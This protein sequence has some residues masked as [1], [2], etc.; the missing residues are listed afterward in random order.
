MSHR[1]ELRVCSVCQVE[2]VSFYFSKAQWRKEKRIC[3]HCQNKN[4]C[5]SI[6]LQEVQK[7]TQN[8]NCNILTQHSRSGNVYSPSPL[9]SESTKFPFLP[10]D[11]VISDFNF[12]VS[13]HP[14]A[15]LT[16]TQLTIQISP[17]PKSHEEYKL[18]INFLYNQLIQVF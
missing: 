18:V 4:R 13:A 1:S 5:E 2:K 9:P 14:S 12:I 16:E 7:N 3:I 8:E 15:P 10:K 11:I 6:T 17:E